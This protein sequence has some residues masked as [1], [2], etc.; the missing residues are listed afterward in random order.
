MENKKTF[1]PKVSELRFSFS[2]DYLFILL[3]GL[4]QAIALNVFLV[5]SQLASG[6]IS[7]LSQIINSY[8][9]WPIGAMVLVGNIPLFILG[10]RYLGGFRFARRTIFAVVSFSLIV[11]LT[12]P[13]LPTTGITDDLLLNALYGGI[14]SGIGFGMVYRGRGTSG[15]TDILVRILNNSQGVSLSTGYMM[16]DS[17]IMIMAGLAFSPSHAL[18]AL[19]NLYVSGLAAEA[20]AQG[21]R[22]VRTAMIIT[23]LPDEI[24]AAIISRLDRGVTRLSGKGAYTGEAKDVLYC[25]VSRAETE[26]LKRL[27]EE[28]DPKAFMVIG[29]AKEALGEGFHALSE[30]E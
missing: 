1:F 25:V 29:D 8:T 30:G 13:I 21:S 10:W 19:V 24:C 14:I 12:A 4:L 3:G 2:K 7:G 6:G 22:V 11:D 28:V 16:T 27:V 18:Y 15:G 9:G 5:P 17:I 20:T 23:T 26:R